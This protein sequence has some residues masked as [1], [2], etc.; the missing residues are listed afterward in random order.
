VLADE[1]CN[2]RVEKDNVVDALATL[3]AGCVALVVPHAAR[4]VG[5]HHRESGCGSPRVETRECSHPEP[6]PT[7]AMEHDQQWP[8]GLRGAR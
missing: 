8:I 5:K 4:A 2:Q 1:M 6:G 3:E 7:R